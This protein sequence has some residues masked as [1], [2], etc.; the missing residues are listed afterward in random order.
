MGNL[1]FLFDR[2]AIL[3]LGVAAGVAIGFAFGSGGERHETVTLAPEA[4]PVIGAPAATAPPPPSGPAAPAAEEVAKKEPALA[5]PAPVVAEPMAEAPVADKATGSL[6][7]AVRGGRLVHVGVF[8]DSFGDGVW[9]ALYRLLPATEGYRVTKYSQQSTGFT[10]YRSLNLEAHDDS[11]V[12]SDPVD[13]AVVAFGANDVQ[14]VC[15]GGHCGALMSAYWQQVIGQRITSYI[16]MLR[17]HGASVYWIGL[18]V[19]RDPS[20]DSDTHAM[21]AFYAALMQRLGVPFIEIRPYTADADGNYQ[22]YYQ[23]ADGSQKLL[24]A[25]DGVH[26]SMNGYIRI[27]KTLA[28]RI[29]ATATA[30][31]KDA[32]AAPDTPAQDNGNP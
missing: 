21:D 26:M 31:R 17:R 32:A 11:Q 14:G 27:T 10:R 12:G 8:G 13:V 22:A 30:A 24:R 6:A 5:K 3:F 9:S 20:F 7:D 2:T 18:P 28:G 29:K 19:M 1:R 25:G 15:D 4:A 23:D 16:A